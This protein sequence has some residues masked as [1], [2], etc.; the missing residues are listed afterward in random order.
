M[1]RLIVAYGVALALAATLVIG[2]GDSPMTS[3]DTEAGTIYVRDY[4]RACGTHEGIAAAA[5]DS[6]DGAPFVICN[7]GAGF[8]YNDQHLE[9][10]QPEPERLP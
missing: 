4:V 3:N 9:R 10:V 5:P 1:S 7:D 6:S 8:V 2:C